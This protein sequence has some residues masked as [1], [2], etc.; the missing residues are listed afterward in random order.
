MRSCALPDFIDG[1]FG[2]FT[3]LRF[4]KKKKWEA[5][6]EVHVGG[7]PFSDAAGEGFALRATAG[8]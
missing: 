5:K 8:T 3:A 2:C 6:C 4:A 7:W 1:S